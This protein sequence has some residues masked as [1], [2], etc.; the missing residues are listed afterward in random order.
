MFDTCL[1]K[2]RVSHLNS[3]LSYSYVAFHLIQ[4]PS[5][6]LT[7]F[8]TNNQQIDISSSLIWSDLN[9]DWFQRQKSTQKNTELLLIL[10]SCV[11]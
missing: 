6:L 2:D 10:F 1:K 8:V 4:L 9:G 11:E 3:T 7:L 5:F